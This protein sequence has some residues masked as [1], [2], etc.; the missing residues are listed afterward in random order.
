M[1]DTANS[2]EI[3]RGSGKTKSQTSKF[4]RSDS[5][6]SGFLLRITKSDLQFLAFG[7]WRL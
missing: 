7:Q 5:W 4:Q 1:D 2:K 3:R 6:L